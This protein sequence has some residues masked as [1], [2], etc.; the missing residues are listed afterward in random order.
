VLDAVFAQRDLAD[1]RTRLDA[2]GVTFGAVQ[3]VNE[4]AD[5]TQMHQI[6]ALVPFADGAGLT[7][8][9]PFHLEGETKVAPRRA[10]ALG[11]HTDL[12]LRE[13]GYAPDEI[14]RLRALGVLA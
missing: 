4:T 3:S 8:S 5:D 1:W 2:A 13:A 7:V 11:E 9:S 6:G 12:V 14:A 10:P